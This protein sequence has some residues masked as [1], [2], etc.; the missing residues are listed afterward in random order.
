MNTLRRITA[1]GRTGFWMRADS[2]LN[3]RV[4]AGTMYKLLS[5]KSAYTLTRILSHHL[6]HQMLRAR[7]YGNG[8]W[9]TMESINGLRGVYCGLHGLKASL[10]VPGWVSNTKSL[11]SR[12]QRRHLVTSQSIYLNPPFSRL[13]GLRDGS[14]SDTLKAFQLRRNERPTR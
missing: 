5:V 6:G 4:V 7:L 12:M 2:N 14:A 13:I 3:V 9:A 10:Y 11:R 1:G 8:R